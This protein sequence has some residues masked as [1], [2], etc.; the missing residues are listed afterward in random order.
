MNFKLIEERYNVMKSVLED[1]F[2]DYTVVIY[3]EKW[4]VPEVWIELYDRKETMIN[5]R[6]F[7]KSD[8]DSELKNL[9]KLA[10]EKEFY[11]LG[12]N[13]GKR[14]EEGFP[15]VVRTYPTTVYGELEEFVIGGEKAID[16]YGNIWILE[17][18]Y[19]TSGMPEVP[20]KCFQR[21][22]L[23]KVPPLVRV[24]YVT[25][26]K[27]LDSTINIKIETIEQFPVKE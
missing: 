3:E 1:M 21:Y 7:Y 18:E 10:F 9:V 16:E 17:N 8:I 22:K 25:M 23:D 13:S 11:F 26:E 15:E 6:H 27:I 20:A 24:K 4:T 5:S 14:K 2:K 12:Q 19:V